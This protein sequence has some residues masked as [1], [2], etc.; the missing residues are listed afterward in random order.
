MFFTFP[1]S[2]H[3]VQNYYSL[4]HLTYL[5]HSPLGASRAEQLGGVYRGTAIWQPHHKM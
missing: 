4:Q 3:L 5:S 2:I 1:L